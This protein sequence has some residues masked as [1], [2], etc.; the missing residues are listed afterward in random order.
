MSKIKYVAVQ[1]APEAQE[2]PLMIDGDGDIRM[3]ESVLFGA[4]GLLRGNETLLRII[5]RFEDYID[6]I[7]DM[8]NA[9]ASASEIVKEIQ[10]YFSHIVG[11]NFKMKDQ[12]IYWK[13]AVRSYKDDSDSFSVILTCVTGNKYEHTTIRGCSQSDWAELYYPARWSDDEID[14]FAAEY[15][16]TGDEW[17][18]TSKDDPDDGVSVYTTSYGDEDIKKEIAGNLYDVCPDEIEIR[19]LEGYKRIPQYR[20]A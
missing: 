19:V 6:D 16:N 15:F 4:R 14:R 5:N 8:L 7:A 13:D 9:P 2:S 18:V 20:I 1:K 10:G 11:E 17:L 3:Q 12:L